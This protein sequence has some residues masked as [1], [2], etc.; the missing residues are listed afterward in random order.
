MRLK[1][2]GA[3]T[4]GVVCTIASWY[5]AAFQAGD[6]YHLYF[7]QPAAFFVV[8]TVLLSREVRASPANPFVHVF[9]FV[10]ALRYVVMPVSIV[11]AGHYGGRSWVP[12]LADSIETATVLMIWELLLC[13]VALSAFGRAYRR[14]R[15]MDRAGGV[16]T[17]GEGMLS[18]S[19][20]PNPGYL[21]F[22]GA[23]LLLVALFPE[24]AKSVNVLIPRT[25]AR[26]LADANAGVKLSAHA[27]LVMKSLIFALIVM[28]LR[29][30]Y[31]R[32]PSQL[33]VVLAL[34]A[35]AANSLIYVGSS[36]QD[37][38][39]TGVASFLFL[40]AVFGHTVRKY[41][42]VAALVVAIPLS[43]VT[44]EREIVVT[45]TGSERLADTLQVYAGGPYNVAM[46]VETLDYFP[47]ARS[48]AVLMMDFFRPMLGVNFLLKSV[49]VPYTNIYFN[50]RIWTH[51]DRRSQIIPMVGQGYIFFG[52]A[53]AP[54][55][56]VV[57]IGIAF[58][59]FRLRSQIDNPELYYFITYSLVR[60]GLMMGQN[61]MN[62]VNE[63]SLNL[64]LF[65]AVYIVN[66]AL[67]GQIALRRG[68][69]GGIAR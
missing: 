61:S 36:R 41:S 48:P 37:I 44:S 19:R 51:V 12:P 2:L 31:D 65:T 40:M 46:A 15:R 66:R 52:F 49:D 27:L 67:R 6:G 54:V 16:A 39:I 17:R 5:V 63:L 4:V 57:F 29:R 28:A 55:I 68:A 30:R 42:V 38:L 14:R 26:D 13:S 18:T 59:L 47:E 43:L 20:L 9:C 11:W 21:I 50:K 45:K 10:A 69:R 33:I 62:M 34:A 22:G 35:A 8:Y 25:L 58:W 7:L 1:H 3:F 60:L 24:G 32:K 23:C 64:F 53:L 56:S